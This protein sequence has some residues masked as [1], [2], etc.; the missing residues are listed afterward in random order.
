MTSNDR[1]QLLLLPVTLSS[2]HRLNVTVGGLG[3]GL[4]IYT[5]QQPAHVYSSLLIHTDEYSLV[6]SI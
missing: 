6:Y 2:T 3:L 5:G 1:A 4:W